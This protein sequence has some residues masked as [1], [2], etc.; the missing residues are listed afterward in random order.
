M[1]DYKPPYNFAEGAILLVNKPLEWTS[2]D[3]VK[4]LKFTLK[5]KVGHA[6]TLDPLADGLLIIGTG[7]YTKKLQELQNLGKAYKGVIKFGATTPSFDRE[8]EEENNKDISGLT[9]ELIHEAAKS[10]TGDQMQM[11][12]MFSAIKRGVEKTIRIRAKRRNDNS[13]SKASHY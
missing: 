9:E 4:K 1:I 5:V 10:F 13:Y 8:S 7:R 11:P 3:V 2:F 6:G 12:P